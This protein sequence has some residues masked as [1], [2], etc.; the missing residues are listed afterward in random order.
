MNNSQFVKHF[1]KDKKSK[2]RTSND[3][4]FQEAPIGFPTRAS[5]K[6]FPK[7]K[8]QFNRMEA[9][10]LRTVFFV[11]IPIHICLL[12]VDVIIYQIEIPIIVVDLIFIWL[13]FVNYMTLNKIMTIA[14]LLLYFMT[15]ITSLSHTQRV[16]LDQKSMVVSLCFIFQF[17]IIYPIALIVGA[18]KFV[19]HFT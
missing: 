1:D 18:N 7:E 14:E 6:F 12:F 10:N 8:K 11:M 13:N 2:N 16:F 17:F 15:I 3:D 9:K 4:H 5:F 19:K